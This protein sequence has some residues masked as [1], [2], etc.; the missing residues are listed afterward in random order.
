M[1]NAAFCKFLLQFQ[2]F[3]FVGNNNRVDFWGVSPK[4]LRNA[5]GLVS[6]RGCLILVPRATRLNL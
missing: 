5:Q 3:E 2:Q 1:Y 4:T 6:S